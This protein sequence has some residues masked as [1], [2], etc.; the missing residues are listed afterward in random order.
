MFA[1]R[2]PVNWEELRKAEKALV[3]VEEE[4]ERLQQQI[5]TP[6]Q[7]LGYLEAI[8]RK[9]DE[10]LVVHNQFF[11][12]NWMGVRVDDLPGSDG[13]DITLAEFSLQEDFRRSAVLVSFALGATTS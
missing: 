6:E 13:N 10:T 3:E 5:A 4:L 11:R 8:M 12:L 1:S 9:P 7:S 2:D